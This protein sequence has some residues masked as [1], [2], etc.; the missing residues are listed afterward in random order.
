MTLQRESLDRNT[1]SVHTVLVKPYD[2]R[3]LKKLTALCWEAYIGQ[4]VAMVNT[5]NTSSKIWPGGRTL[6]FLPLPDEQP[7]LFALEEPAG[8]IIHRAR[9]YKPHLL[10]VEYFTIA[11]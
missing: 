7:A 8:Y 11:I 6:N 10:S 9:L 3:E 1:A 2:S 5:V 4:G